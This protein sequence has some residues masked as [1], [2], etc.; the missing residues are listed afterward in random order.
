LPDENRQLASNIIH[1]LGEDATPEPTLRDLLESI[2]TNI[3]AVVMHVLLKSG[4]AW[5]DKVPAEIR[6]KCHERR[7]SEG[8]QH[9][10]EAY[11]DLIDYKKI[12]AANWDLF[13]PLFEAEG[14][15]GGKNKILHGVDKANEMRK[16]NAHP[17]KRLTVRYEPSSADLDCLRDTEHVYRKLYKRVK[18]EG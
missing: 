10:L 14:I 12:M 7:S 17:S 5:L 4:S 15:A 18:N 1:W 3:R 8:A 11:F 13:K 9:A 16:W 2:E 6:N